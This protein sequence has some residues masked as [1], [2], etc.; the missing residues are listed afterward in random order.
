MLL[1]KAIE[2]LTETRNINLN[3]YSP[4]RKDALQLG[5]KAMKRLEE[6]RSG[7]VLNPDLLLPGEDKP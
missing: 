5:I 1:N 3:Y 6:W 2:I 7:T 4:D